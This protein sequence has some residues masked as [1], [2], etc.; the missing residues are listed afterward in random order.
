MNVLVIKCFFAMIAKPKSSILAI[1][2][3]QHSLAFRAKRNHRFA[4]VIG[5][6]HLPSR[7]W[8]NAL[9]IAAH[10]K[11]HLAF[12]RILPQQNTF[13]ANGARCSFLIL[14]QRE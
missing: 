6:K 9:L 12:L 4:A 11:V 3:C 1:E 14:R 13:T 5:I 2:L 8:R 10:M 7:I